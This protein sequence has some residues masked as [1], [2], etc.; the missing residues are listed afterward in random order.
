MDPCGIFCILLSYAAVAY[1]DYVVI[2][3]LIL[4]TLKNSLWGAFHVAIFNI[5]LF[6]LLYSHSKAMTADPGIVPLPATRI[7]F[8][9]LRSAV[10]RSG[11]DSDVSQRSF[12]GED[13]TVCGRCESYRPPRA[14]HCRV[15]KRCIRKMDHH[16]PWINNCVGEYNQKYF[17]LFLIYT[18]IASLYCVGI[19]VFTWMFPCEECLIKE[20]VQQARVLHTIFVC[21]ECALFCLF[22]IAVSCDQFQA[23]ISDETAIE[24]IQRRG[25]FRT[26][27]GSKMLLL[28][29]VFG[30]GPIIFWLLPCHNS[31]ARRD[32]V[33]VASHYPV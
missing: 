14:H 20:S 26:E 18:G 32:Y 12:V 31:P 33:R 9:D 17:I 28:R 3:W 7:D 11:S 2:E 24:Q 4:P 19:V 10:H 27:T 21:I 16:C 5:L 29:E 6:L 23:I 30:N 25:S 8:S 1:A 13:W 22:V 15:C